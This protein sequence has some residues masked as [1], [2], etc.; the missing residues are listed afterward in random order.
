MRIYRASP[1]RCCHRDPGYA[2]RSRIWRPTGTV[3]G[4]RFG[5]IVTVP[6]YPAPEAARSR[7]TIVTTAISLLYLVA[8]IEVINAL[9]AF[10]TSGRMT[11]AVR[12]VYAG[13]EAEGAESFVSVVFIGGGVIN[14]L[15]GL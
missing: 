2:A 3:N 14:L 13:T 6:S 15:L 5:G 7:P 4:S 1:A 11:D 8:G 9:V 12:D 10:S